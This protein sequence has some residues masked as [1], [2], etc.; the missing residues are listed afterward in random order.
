MTTAVATT[1][2]KI[3]LRLHLPVEEIDYWIVK[4]AAAYA[5]RYSLAV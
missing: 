1:R 5:S 4:E 2:P 3:D